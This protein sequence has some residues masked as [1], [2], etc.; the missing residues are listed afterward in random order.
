MALFNDAGPSGYEM[1]RREA[2]YRK[3]REYEKYSYGNYNFKDMN[4]L[5]NSWVP[6]SNCIIDTDVAST[7]ACDPQQTLTPSRMQLVDNILG[8]LVR[9]KDGRYYEFKKSTKKDMSCESNKFYKVLK[10]LPAW[11]AGAIIRLNSDGYTSVNELFNKEHTGGEYYETSRIVENSPE[12]FER[13]Y[14]VS[15]LTKVVYKAKAEARELFSK[16]MTQ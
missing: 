14:P 2:D 5:Y 1:S 15:L 12:W 10:D 13:V 8:K 16:E 4:K 7:T 3:A 11:E 6:Y 9:S